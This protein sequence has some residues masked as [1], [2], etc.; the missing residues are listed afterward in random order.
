M[1]FIGKII[2]I[3][4]GILIM[5]AIII[6]VMLLVPALVMLVLLCTGMIL[7]CAWDIGNFKSKLKELKESLKSENID[8]EE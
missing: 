3:I 4:G 2:A 6:F 5:I 8:E 7:T 1:N